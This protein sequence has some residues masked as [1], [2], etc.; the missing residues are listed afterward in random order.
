[1]KSVVARL[2]A[3]D[4]SDEEWEGIRLRSPHPWSFHQNNDSDV[5]LASEGQAK[6]DAEKCDSAKASDVEDNSTLRPFCLLYRLPVD[7]TFTRLGVS[8]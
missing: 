7:L 5:T 8:I 2:E 4:G 6:E 1:M 3:G